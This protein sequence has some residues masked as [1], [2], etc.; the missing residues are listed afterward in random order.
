MALS[1]K[2]KFFSDKGFGFITPDDGSEDVFVHFSAINKDGFKSLNE[3]ETVT[4]DKVFDD[5]K[6]K[7]SAANVTGQ[8]DGERRR[9]RYHGGGDGGDG[10]GMAE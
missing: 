7:W 5:A 2:V 9:R 6:Q 3:N 4:Y 8:G 10:G 1:G